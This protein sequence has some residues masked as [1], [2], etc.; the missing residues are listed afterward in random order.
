M[1]PPPPLLLALGT[2]ARAIETCTSQR[3]LCAHTSSLFVTVTIQRDVLMCQRL[4]RSLWKA[5]EEYEGDDPILPWI[6]CAGPV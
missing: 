5:V 6:R 4:C 1:R 3:T 2:S